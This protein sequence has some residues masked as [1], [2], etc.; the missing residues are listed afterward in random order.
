MRAK[1][2]KSRIQRVAAS[3]SNWLDRH[4][5]SSFAVFTWEESTILAKITIF[6]PVVIGYYAA[7]KPLMLLFE[8]VFPRMDP[9]FEWFKD[10]FDRLFIK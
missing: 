10:T 2:I 3:C 8:E 6:V 9:V 1:T 4:V 7:M 5:S